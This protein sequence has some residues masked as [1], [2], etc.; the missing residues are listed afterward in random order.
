M[1]IFNK[2]SKYVIA[3]KNMSICEAY[4]NFVKGNLRAEELNFVSSN[5]M[6]LLK[7]GE[8]ARNAI[9]SVQKMLT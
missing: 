1:T 5:Y 7:V 3:N 2:F 8:S 9:P 4:N 6:L